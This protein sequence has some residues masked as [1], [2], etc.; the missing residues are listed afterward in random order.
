LNYQKSKTFEKTYISL[1]FFLCGILLPN[2]L[3]AFLSAKTPFQV[4]TEYKVQT[5][6]LFLLLFILF[7]TAYKIRNFPQVHVGRTLFFFLLW[8]AAGYIVISIIITGKITVLYWLINIALQYVTVF[9]W[10]IVLKKIQKKTFIVLPGGIADEL[11]NSNEL[12]FTITVLNKPD[13]S[14]IQQKI[15][16]IVLDTLIQR[17]SNWVRFISKCQLNGISVYN[18]EDIYEKATGR[19]SLMHLSEGILEEFNTNYWYT[20]FKRAID[21]FLILIALPVIL[22]VIALTALA[23][24][25]ESPGPVIFKQKRIGAKAKEYTMYKFRSMVDMEDKKNAAFAQKEDK[26]VT[27]VGKLIRGNRIDELPQLW[28]IIK[29]NMSLIG[30]R[31]EQVDF[32]EQFKES[33]P[34]Y[35]YRHMVKP[36]ISGWSQ[37]IR[38]YTADEES[39][40]EKLEYDLYYIKHFSFW[41]DMIIAVKTIKTI[42]TGFGAR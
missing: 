21:I 36:G 34:Y 9:L 33:I 40:R 5:A 3:F 16:G 12:P 35:G 17:S 29:G 20:G 32:V 15:D 38:G 4:F 41:L 13:F 23:I 26:R 2:L 11:I 6:L 10:N 28:N 31:P 42:F 24:K 39:T 14:E 19:V 1:L 8:Y 25:L 30:P 22:P 27:R 7:Y 18:A 37:V